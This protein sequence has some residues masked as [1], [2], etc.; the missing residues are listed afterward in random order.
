MNSDQEGPNP[1]EINPNAI[2]ST[3]PNIPPTLNTRK[4]TVGIRDALSST[5]A[6]TE[7]LSTIRTFQ[8]DVSDR[9]KNDNVS[10]IKIAIAEKERRERNNANMVLE[11]NKKMTPIYIFSGVIAILIISSVGFVYWYFN[12][13]LPPTL[14]QTIAPNEPEI[15]YSETQVAVSTDNKSPADMLIDLRK[16]T[17]T[18]LDLGTMKRILVTTKLGSSTRNLNAG[19][20]LTKIR[21]RASENLIRAMEP[22]FVIGAYS[23]EPHDVFIIFKIN[24]YDIAYPGLLAWE[25]YMDADL[26]HL[27]VDKKV[28]EI[29]A[30]IIPIVA[31]TSPILVATTSAST[32]ATASLTSTSSTSTSTTPIIATGTPVSTAPKTPTKTTNDPKPVWKDKIIQ[33]KDTRVLIDTDGNMKFL[34]SFVD[35]NTLVIVSNEKGFKE[36]I[37]RMTTGRVRR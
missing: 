25:P 9:V 28:E 5:D 6:D 15:I 35:K 31:T 12:R 4:P 32:T 3:D 26:S 11:K 27:F 22:Y 14:E 13:P 2:Q 37:T 30:P 8:S 36:I 20:F 21:S 18:P 16:E 7:P 24:T 29:I 10:M 34:Y 1:N 17:L 33:N 23:F 19:E